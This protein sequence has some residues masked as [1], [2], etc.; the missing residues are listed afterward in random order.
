MF[1]P[2]K[3]GSD[4]EGEQSPAFVFPDYARRASYEINIHVAADNAGKWAAIR[5][6][7]GGSDGTAYDTRADAVRHQLHE[8]YCCYVKIPPDGMSPED[9]MRYISLH[10]GF[11][12]AGFRFIDPEGPAPILPLGIEQQDRLMAGLL[13]RA[14]Q[15]GIR[16]S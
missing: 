14:Q 7:D 16:T 4:D 11:Y 5:L 9:A 8:Q 13:Q 10:R 2:Q 15:R 6:H 1:P 12:D 3:P